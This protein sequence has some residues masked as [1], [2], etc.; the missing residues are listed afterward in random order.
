MCCSV[1]NDLILSVQDG[2]TPL[3]LALS[4]RK[5]NLI[6]VLM[7]KGANAEKKNPVIQYCDQ[8]LCGI[9][10]LSDWR[11]STFDCFSLW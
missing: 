4:Q 1:E 6:R 11:D 10:E 8:E 5:V 9:I 2:N 3:F 7:N